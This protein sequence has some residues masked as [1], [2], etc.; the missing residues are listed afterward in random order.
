MKKL[1]FV[2]LILSYFGCASTDINSITDPDYRGTQIKHLLIVSGIQDI[3]IKKSIEQKFIQTITNDYDVIAFAGYDIL[4]PTRN[5]TKEDYNSIFTKYNI[6]SILILSITDIGYKTETY[7][8]NQPYVTQGQMTQTGNQ[9]QYSSKTYGGPQTYT[10]KKPYL[11][12]KTEIFDPFKN[13]LI[14]VAT[15]N[16]KGNSWVNIN[17]VLNNYIN[18]VAKKLAQDGLIIPKPEPVNTTTDISDLE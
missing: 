9:Y 2:F 8:D 11:S 15:S 1:L 10:N 14:W 13:K 3:G 17:F 18:E 12:M 5:Y 6:D 16:S 4:P 7:T